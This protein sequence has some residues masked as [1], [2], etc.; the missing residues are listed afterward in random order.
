L[1]ARRARRTPGAASHAALDARTRTFERWFARALPAANV[2]PRRLHAAMRYAALGPGKR[3]RPLLTLAA[4]EA[5]G[6]DWRQALAAAAA[7]ECVHAFSLV[8]D[9]LPALD[10]D[11]FRRGR[12]TLHRRY[13]EALAL[14]AGDA[15]L[16]LGFECLS[17][18]DRAGVPAGR[19]AAAQLVLARASGSRE[20]VGGQVM[21]LEAEGRR[22][23]AVRVRDIH[24]RKTGALMGAALEIGAIVGGVRAPRSREFGRLGRELGIAFQI[25]DDLLN[26]GSSLARLGKRA[27]TDAKRGKATYPRAVGETQARAEA[28]RRLTRARRRIAALGERGGTLLQ[29]LDRLSAREA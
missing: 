26:L 2:A 4:C 22:T 24:A 14:L 7:L 3:V 6:G 10:D 21:D 17:R 12:P 13:G 23:N 25:Q 27:G 5:A 20:L 9:D 18:L 28:K 16:A 1:N 8:H 19:I 29:L 15:L 11:D